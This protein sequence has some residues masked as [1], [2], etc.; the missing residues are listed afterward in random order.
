MQ[1]NQI[2]IGSRESALAQVQSR[3]V[4][5]FLEKAHPD[6]D[7]SLVT[8]KTTG[9]KILDRRLD[10]IGGKGLFVRELDEA[11]LD[12]RT[13]FSV[14]SL[15]DLPMEIPEEL[16]LICYSK[17][18]DPRDVLVLPKGKTALDLSLPIGTSSLR[19]I[20]QLKELY[21]DAQ[22]ASVRGNLQ[23]RLRKLDEGQYSGIILAAAGLKRM[24]LAGRISRYF[25]TE[26]VIPAAGQAILAVQG[27]AGADVSLFTGFADEEAACAATAERAF[28]RRLD[29]GCSSPIAA[30]AVLSDD[31]LTLTGLYADEQITFTEKGSLSGRKEDAE[32]IG[33][34]LAD[35]LREKAQSR[36]GKLQYGE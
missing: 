22:F 31:L 20:L 32:I 26:E 30:H 16:P 27:R 1:N 14:H 34:K 11:L 24:G 5:S 28:V 6:K 13:D 12:G 4:I 23:T 33:I 36:I 17:R 2:V 25:S 8:M 9:D 29:G 35:Q 18:E 10:Q 3:M 21:P 19:R 7:I 15:K